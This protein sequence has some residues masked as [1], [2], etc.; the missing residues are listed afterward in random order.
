LTRKTLKIDAVISSQPA[1]LFLISP[2]SK[3][4]R[5]IIRMELSKSYPQFIDLMVKNS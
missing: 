5:S 3:R 4:E 2:L 1:L